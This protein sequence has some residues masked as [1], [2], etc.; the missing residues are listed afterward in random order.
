M[1][2]ADLYK[3]LPNQKLIILAGGL[4]PASKLGVV[5]YRLNE[6]DSLGLH[7]SFKDFNA[8]KYLKNDGFDMVF[9][10]DTKEKI[11]EH[12]SFTS[13]IVIN[14]QSFTDKKLRQILSA[15]E[16]ETVFL[17]KLEDVRELYYR[18]KDYKPHAV[19]WDLIDS[20]TMDVYKDEFLG[21]VELSISTIPIYKGCMDNFN[22][23][24]R[25]LG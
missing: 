14:A 11:S 24:D 6:E 15:T 9:S 5:S 10:V 8:S 3:K 17:S 19:L 16:G 4:S 1:L 7:G 23:M 13:S 2:K 20:F 25:K 22:F 18:F 12:L 21:G